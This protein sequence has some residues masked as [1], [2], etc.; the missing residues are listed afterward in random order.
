MV[1]VNGWD[2]ENQFI[3]MDF[4]NSQFDVVFDSDNN[5][6][7]FV[8]WIALEDCSDYG[9]FVWPFIFFQEQYLKMIVISI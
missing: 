4:G 6:L 5:E 2:L 8:F 7:D 3:D 9:E 1:K